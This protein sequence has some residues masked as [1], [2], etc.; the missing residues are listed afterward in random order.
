MEKHR[1]YLVNKF[2]TQ[3]QDVVFLLALLFE[4]RI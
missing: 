3:G 2:K 4:K 1:A